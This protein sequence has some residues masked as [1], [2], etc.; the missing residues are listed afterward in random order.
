MQA[1]LDTETVATLLNDKVDDYD[2][3]K[4]AQELEF[5]EIWFTS[6]LVIFSIIGFILSIALLYLFSKSIYKSKVLFIF[7]KNVFKKCCLKL[8]RDKSFLNIQ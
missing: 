4:I 6:T 2:L 1:I 5:Y 3:E 7:L 8:N